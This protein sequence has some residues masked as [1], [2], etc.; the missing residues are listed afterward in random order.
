MQVLIEGKSEDALKDPQAL[1]DM[2]ALQNYAATLPNIGKVVSLVDFVKMMNKA[3]SCD[4]DPSTSDGI[5]VYLGERIDAAAI[6]DRVQVIGIV[7]EYYGM[8][9]ILVA[10][11]DVVQISHDNPLPSPY[12]LNPPVDNGAARL[13]FESLEA[14]SV[15]L[16][17]ALVV[18]PTD[19]DDRTWL[20]SS[21]L[22][23]RRVFQ[24]DPAGTGEVICVDDGGLFEIEP[25]AQ[26][27]DRVLSISGVLNYRLG[28]YCIQLMAA[29]FLQPGA[30]T[31]DQPASLPS[32]APFFRLATFNLAELFDT[33]NDPL[34]EDQ[35]LTEYE[36]QRRLQKRALAIAEELTYPA[37][38]AVQEAENLAVLSDLIERP[39]LE[40]RYELVHAEGLD[41]RGLDV[42]LLYRPDLV[43]VL[44]TE[45]AQGCTNLVDGFEPDGNGDPEIPQNA[46]TCDRNGD[47]VLDGN[48][49]FSRP[50]L[51]VHLWARLEISQNSSVSKA[52]LAYY[53]FW[54]VV[55][56]F[57]SKVGDSSTTAY[58]LPRR[59]EQA[60]FVASLAR[61]IRELPP[62]ILS[63]GA[64][65]LQRLP[66][67]A[68]PRRT[69]RNRLAQC[70]VPI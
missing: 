62:P 13:Y 63:G 2:E 54:V 20:V 39:E 69:E 27:G 33:F 35:V 5:F 48:R 30:A 8:T 25:E 52:P 7:D 42:A 22:G 59:I 32:G 60:Q 46:L 70:N 49:L 64:W 57:K 6:G 43:N 14:M 40:V 17:E 61:S 12:D 50:P 23:I 26:V 44:D 47:G 15:R 1:K 28:I 66:R 21:A 68:A 45:S 29:P 3:P 65:R 55:V 10:P 56:H 19:S 9:E 67:F 37:L 34:T 24:D 53:D 4:T 58:T 51:V 31:L 41:V 16:E 36:Y 38:L 18:G 11:Q